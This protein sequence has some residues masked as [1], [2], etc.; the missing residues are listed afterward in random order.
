MGVPPDARPR[1]FNRGNWL[2]WVK[3]LQSVA[4]IRLRV[5]VDLHR[6][7]VGAIA[8]QQRQLAG[9][10]AAAEGSGSDDDG[11]AEWLAEEDHQLEDLLRQAT[12]SH[13]TY[14]FHAVESE[15][16]VPFSWRFSGLQKGTREK[17]VRRLHSR[18]G[19]E[20]LTNTYFR[21]PL[22]A[23]DEYDTFDHLRNLANASKHHEGG[24]TRE[25]SAAK[26]WRRGDSI[27]YA[28]VDLE[29][30]S[31]TAL[32]FLSDFFKRAE[33]GIRGIFGNPGLRKRR[34]S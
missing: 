34:R 21:F 13:A 19:L 28:D 12:L 23:V 8:Q 9:R 30:L 4:R 7:V 6:L 1:Q 31:A 11:F 32:R 24:V 10:I 22:S 20:N 33:G 25:L 18:D 3:M 17:L 14:L 2:P 26:G 27:S 15:L 16:R 29:A 5:V